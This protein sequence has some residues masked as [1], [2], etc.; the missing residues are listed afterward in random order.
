MRPPREPCRPIGGVHRAFP[1]PC[2]K[3]LPEAY[4]VTAAFLGIVLSPSIARLFIRGFRVVVLHFGLCLAFA[5][6]IGSWEKYV[7][8]EGL[9]AFCGMATV[10]YVGSRVFRGVWGEV[11]VVLRSPASRLDL[12][13]PHGKISKHPASLSTPCVESH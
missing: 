11:F 9:A 4:T 12:S 6:M 13:C 2:G 7:P 1:G 3:T 5:L 10:P 8:V